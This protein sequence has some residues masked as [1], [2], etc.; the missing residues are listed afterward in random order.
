MRT[1]PIIISVC[2]LL[3][4][5]CK[6]PFSPDIESPKQGYLVIEGFLDTANPTEIRL[7]RTRGLQE[8]EIAYENGATV[9]V[10]TE[11]GSAFNLSFHGDGLYS[12]PPLALGTEKA[13][14]RIVT[15]GNVTYLSDFVESKM[16][17][18]IDSVTW[19]RRD[20]GVHVLVNTH[21]NHNQTHYYF[22]TYEET[23]HFRSLY[24][25]H[26]EYAGDGEVRVREND[27][28][29]CW[30]S[31]RSTGVY[32]ANTTGLS[33]DRV[34][35]QRLLAIPN[36]SEKLGVKYSILVKQYALTAE[37]HQ[38][39]EVLQ[40][41]TEEMGSIFDPQPSNLESN[42]RNVD[43][44]NE[45]VVGYISISTMRQKRIFID[46]VELKD[47]EIHVPFYDDCVLTQAGIP[48]YD[49]Y[50]RIRDYIPLFHIRDAVGRIVAY[51]TTFDHCADC[52]IRGTNVRPAFWPQ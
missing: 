37:A 11:S 20:D 32:L 13:R 45:P 51:T 2:C 23:W 35:G 21:D 36:L 50:F 8:T 41:N 46:N 29:N 40:K 52:T 5:Q 44:I 6:D 10:E 1:L 19:E 47:W 9:T 15:A 7:T 3:L 12:A 4:C 38:Y 39:W 34:I 33:D 26:Y 22:W 30:S 49:K 48:E 18:P 43:D 28:Y 27:I 24:E 16:A 25:S 14:L 31:Q 42:I 17:P